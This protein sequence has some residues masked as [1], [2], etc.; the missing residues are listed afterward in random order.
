[1]LGEEERKTYNMQKNK[2]DG[3]CRV[4]KKQI[5]NGEFPPDL[6]I[7]LDDARKLRAGLYHQEEEE[8]EEIENK[9]DPVAKY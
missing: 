9:S 4:V 6:K 2:Y 7:S 8:E 3:A 1:M 5:E